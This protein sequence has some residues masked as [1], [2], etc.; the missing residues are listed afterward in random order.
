LF[1]VSTW[2]P[3]VYLCILILMGLA[4]LVS[5]LIPA[6]QASRVQPTQALRYE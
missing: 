2:E 4:T 1:G 5:V 6:W 3:L